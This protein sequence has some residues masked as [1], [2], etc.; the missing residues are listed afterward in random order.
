MHF[1]LLGATGTVTGSKTPLQHQD[2]RLLVDCGLFQGLKPLRLR[3]WERLA[4]APGEID[5]VLLTHAHIDHSGFLPRLVAQGFRGPVYCSEATLELACLLLPDSARLQQQEADFADRHGHSRHHPVLPLYTE[6]EALQAPA[7]RA[8]RPHPRCGEPAPGMGRPQP[9]P[10]PLSPS[11]RWPPLPTS[12]STSASA[13]NS[14]VSQKAWAGPTACTCPRSTRT[15]RCS[16]STSPRPWRGWAARRRASWPTRWRCASAT[17]TARR[18]RR[19]AGPAD[20]QR[21]HPERRAGTAAR[22]LVD[23]GH[24]SAADEAGVAH[25]RLPR[26]RQ[27]RRLLRPAVRRRCRRRWRG[28]T[29]G[30]SA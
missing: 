7:A 26:R 21:G 3:N 14:K 28:T 8:G 22:D 5:A 27:L 13:M 24:R 12:A 1:Q 2:R 11:P 18:R 10:R 4:S 19:G 23:D 9:T 25:G 30:G 16:A 15:C 29:A 17:P 20:P 6:T